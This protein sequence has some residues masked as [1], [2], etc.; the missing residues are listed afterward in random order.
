MDGVTGGG[1]SVGPEGGNPYSSWEGEGTCAP[2]QE[3]DL[4][5]RVKASRHGSHWITIGRAA[6]PGE[7][8]GAVVPPEGPGEPLE[9]VRLDGR[10]VAEAQREI[11]SRGLT[12]DYV[13][14]RAVTA[15]GS[16]TPGYM[17]QP[18]KSADPA[19]KVVYATM[20]NAKTVRLIVEGP[21]VRPGS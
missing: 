3:C 16:D 17:E 19:A 5:L 21:P 20:V 7:N 8:Y 11:R 6:R 4:R 15:P 13:L 2:E 9:G 12:P 18:A 1:S 10:T 14:Q